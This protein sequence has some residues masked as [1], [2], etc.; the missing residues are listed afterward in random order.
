MAT[1]AHYGLVKP[2]SSKDV[3]EEFF[4]LQD[5]LDT[6]DGLLHDHEMAIG[7]RAPLAHDHA[8]EDILGLIAAL[9]GKMNASMTFK[10]D[11]LT[12]VDGADAAPVGYILVKTPT[13]W[14]PF[15]AATALGNHN[16]STA[17][18]NGLD[19][20]LLSK[21]NTSAVDTSAA[22]GTDDAKVPSQKAVK[23][24]VDGL[25]TAIRN[26]VSASFDTLKELADNFASYLPLIG[27]T[28]TG[29]LLFNLGKNIKL[30]G[31]TAAVGAISWLRDADSTTGASIYHNPNTNGLTI[32]TYTVAGG[33]KNTLI[34]SDTTFGEM[35]LNGSPVWHA[36]NFD[37]AAYVQIAATRIKVTAVAGGSPGFEF[38]DESNVRRGIVLWNYANGAL[39]L[40]NY[41]AD[42]ATILN[43]TVIAGTAGGDLVHNGVTVATAGNI[44]S[45]YG[46]NIAVGGVGAIQ[47]L[48]HGTLNTALT[49]GATYAGSALKI[50][51]LFGDLSTMGVGLASAPAGT[52]KCLGSI[53]AQAGKYS[54]SLF[55]RI[56]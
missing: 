12:D 49:Y 26:G 43:T 55:L 20:A 16:H 34:V 38:Y 23:T 17:Q 39:Q 15:S 14:Q 30:R 22:L 53:G 41:A 40:Q 52:W 32:R 42:G 18:V 51:T 44:G 8:M 5:T 33:F 50:A 11:S 2:D 9:N 28:L 21:L 56:A 36:G 29:D 10:L 48:A 45:I 37:P 7:A 24:Y 25:F 6:L 31:G 54:I 46:G 3:D 4:Q 27:G 19:A 1:T 35:T 13:G 47:M